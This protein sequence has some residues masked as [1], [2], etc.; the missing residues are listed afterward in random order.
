M[1]HPI[2]RIATLV[3]LMFLA[4]TISTTMVQFVRADEYRA[5][6]RNVRTIYQEYGSH[7]GPIIV[8]EQPIAY[9][10]EVDDNYAYQRVYEQVDLYAH[11]TGYFSVAFNSATGLERSENGVLGGKADTLAFD[12]I[13]QLFTGEQSLGG[14]I[15]LTIDPQLQRV[16]YDALGGQRGSVVAFEPDTGRI[17]AMVSYPSFD[18]NPIAS[19]SR[20]V[21]EEAYTALEE[22]SSKPLINRAIGGDLYT[23]GSVFKLITATAMVEAGTKPTDRVDAPTQYSPPGTTHVI[24]NPGEARC[25]D[26]SGQVPLIDAVKQSCNTPF[27]MAAVELGDEAMIKQAEK[28]GFGQDL[29]IPLPVTPSIYPTPDSTSTLA[30]SGFGQWEVRVTPLQMAMVAGAIA[31]DGVVM[32]PYLVD[33]VLG[34]D[35]D[36]VSTTRPEELSRA[37]SESTAAAMTEMMVEVVNNGTGYRAQIDGVQVAGKTGTAEISTQTPPH[38]WFAGFAPADD[39]QIAVA[40]VVENGGNIGFG[41]DG[42]SLAAPIARTVLANGLR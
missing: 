33:R 1:N 40:V 29:D 8:G 7:R 13:R 41:S 24:Q 15:Q 4:L 19:H 20:S 23:P 25:G 17:L 27:A 9:S 35:L 37:M 31:N 16:A 36:V 10:T 5:D 11:L 39:P 28:F 6:S 12:R 42:G 26:G 38:A 18:P 21:A 34:G 14:G 32:K 3:C 22:D 2:R 30:M